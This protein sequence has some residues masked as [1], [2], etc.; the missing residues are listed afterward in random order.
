DVSITDQNNCTASKAFNII[1]YLPNLNPSIISITCYGADNGKITVNATGGVSPYS[2]EW[3]NGDSLATIQNLSPGYYDVTIT[4][5]SGC[6]TVYGDSLY[7]PDSIQIAFTAT[8]ILCNGDTNGTLSS[9]ITGGTSPYT[10]NWSGGS[11]QNNI[12]N[13]SAG[14]YSLSI[15]DLNACQSS[16]SYL[17][18][19][20]DPLQVIINTLDDHCQL[21]LGSINTSIFGGSTPY[22][23][24]WS[25]GQTSSSID[26]LASGS[27]ILI[28]SDA[29]NCMHYDTTSIDTG[30]L[31]VL[32]LSTT[33]S[34]C[35]QPNGSITTSLSTGTPPYQYLWSTNAVT[36]SLSNIS[37]GTYLLTITDSNSC[38][39]TDSAIVNSNF[40]YNKAFGADT[41]ICIGDT[42]SLSVSDI[43]SF[44]WQPTTYINQTS[45]TSLIIEADSNISYEITLFS[46]TCE[47]EDSLHIIVNSLPVIEIS[48]STDTVE[49][50]ESLTLTATG[51]TS[52]SWE[53]QSQITDP[54]TATATVSPTQQSTYYLNVTDNNGCIATDSIT[55]FIKDLAALIKGVTGFSPNGDGI[56]EFWIIDEISTYPNASVS[57]YNR[58]GNLIY[59]TTNYQNNWDGTKNGVAVNEGV[60]FYVIDFND[61]SNFKTGYITLLR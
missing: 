54:N 17:I 57:I 34:D 61:G 24:N 43:D 44:Q 35:D 16:S 42:L 21:D 22:Y 53:P 5:A 6:L 23:Y 31:M 1:N 25:S 37:S 40:N 13:L 20:P 27:Y 33:A 49:S 59:K 15:T 52:Y 51:G 56:N 3:N 12:S 29:N 7:E 58:H 30:S 2:Y 9:S 19:E 45:D 18:S 50:G 41:I 47:A 48:V 14:T 10:Y 55:I 38:T 8:D 39:K 60:Y 4:D 32:N 36:S 26:S 46:G 28:L 11:T